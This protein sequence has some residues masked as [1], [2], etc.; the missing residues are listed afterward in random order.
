[1]H[2]LLEE[3]FDR[4]ASLPA[5]EQEALARRV[6]AELDA[7]A[8]WDDLFAQPESDDLLVRL[9]DEALAAHRDGRTRPLNP[10]A[11]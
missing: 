5:Q 7:D 3:A 10:D 4:A 9:A 1:M 6:L 8:R 11:L 2:Q